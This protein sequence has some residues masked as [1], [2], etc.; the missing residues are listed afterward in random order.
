MAVLSGD[1]ILSVGRSSESKSD[2]LSAES[3]FRSVAA[4]FTNS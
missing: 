4:R 1:R 2:S 3:S